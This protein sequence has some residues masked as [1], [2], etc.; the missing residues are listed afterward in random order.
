V[1]AKERFMLTPDIEKKLRFTQRCVKGMSV[2]LEFPKSSLECDENDEKTFYFTPNSILFLRSTAFPWTRH[3]S[4]KTLQ[5]YVFNSLDNKREYEIRNGVP[6]RPS[7]AEA[8]FGEA[9]EGRVIWH[10]RRDEALKMD[11][12]VKLIRNSLQKT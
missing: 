6:N 9:F 12:L 5:F 11:A 7:E 8:S 2:A 10:W 3:L 4:Q 1:R